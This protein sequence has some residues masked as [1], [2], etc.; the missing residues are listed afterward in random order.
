MLKML[1][2]MFNVTEEEEEKK[3]GYSLIQK[4]FWSLPLHRNIQSDFETHPF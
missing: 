2:M 3:H 1:K 4:Q